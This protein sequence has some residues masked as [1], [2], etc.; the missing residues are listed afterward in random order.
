MREHRDT[1]TFGC[2]TFDGLGG[3]FELVNGELAVP[4]FRVVNIM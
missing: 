4:A 3:M 2:A 1:G